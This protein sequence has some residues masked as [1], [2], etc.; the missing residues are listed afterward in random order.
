VDATAVSE[1]RWVGSHASLSSSCRSSAAAT[2]SSRRCLGPLAVHVQ[3]RVLALI[4]RRMGV[5]LRK[6]EA[7]C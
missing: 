1:C 4:V 5:A 3:A 6:P 2:A 7:Q